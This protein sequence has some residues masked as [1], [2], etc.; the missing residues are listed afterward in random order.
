LLDTV[1]R[2][3]PYTIERC[4]GEIVYLA[5]IE[6]SVCPPPREV[7]NKI[8]EALEIVGPYFSTFAV[9]LLAP[10]AQIYQPILEGL[11]LLARPRFPVRFVT[12]VM[13]AAQWLCA[14]R[15]HGPGEPLSA[16]ALAAAA[17]R[18]RRLD[19]ERQSA[20]RRPRIHAVVSP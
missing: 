7:R 16:T 3:A 9:V 1:V 12:S 19:A 14:T 10:N 13:A 17:E 8:V 2:R 6:P 5:L 4:G 20:R 15:A 18:V 11:M